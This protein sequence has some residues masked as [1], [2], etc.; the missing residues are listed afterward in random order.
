MA[1]MNSTP[2][3]AEPPTDWE[4]LARY[5]AGE[6]RPDEL[7]RVRRWLEEHPDDAALTLVQ[8]CLK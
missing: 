6:S 1:P 3:A 4:A 2:D 7:E 8:G 5:L